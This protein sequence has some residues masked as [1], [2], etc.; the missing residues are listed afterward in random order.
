MVVA[1]DLMEAIEVVQ[2]ETR[3]SEALVA[4]KA[5][6]GI[7]N[8]HTRAEIITVESSTSS[9]TRSSPASLS[10]SSSTSS[11]KDDMPLNR[12]YTNLNK[13]LSPHHQP[14]LIKSQ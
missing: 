3:W 14:K 6:E 1:V 12:V 10:S 2:K 4:S 5:P 7:S 8:S 11:D 9:D 13:G